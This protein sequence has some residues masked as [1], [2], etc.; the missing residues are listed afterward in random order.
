VH[1]DEQRARAVQR[2]VAAILVLNVLVALVKGVYGWLSGSLAVASDALHSLL[3]AGSNVVGLVVLRYASHPPDEEHPY[4]HRKIEIVAAAA[5]GVL[6]TAVAVSFAWSAV[7]ALVGERPAP[8]VSGRG[9]A[10]MAGTLVVNLF[11][12]IYEWRRGKALGSAFLVADAAHTASDVFVTIAVIGS[13]ALSRA[14]VAR[15]DAIAALIVMAVIARV[16]WRILAA[17]VGVLVDHARISADAVR[18]AVRT[19][20]GVEGCHRIRSR[21]PEGA[22][23]LD[24]HLLLEGAMT[25]REAHRRS[26]LVEDA[27]RKRFPEIVDVTIHME[28][29]DEEDEGL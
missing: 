16:A 24:L 20:P 15:A 21:G 4:G 17:N 10:L 25:L 12:A 9:I 18:A 2:V 23:Q 27:L 29:E 11:V 8:V 14:G 6:I 22:V 19:V 3:D 1:G 26:H 28:P 5:I 13:L 7:E